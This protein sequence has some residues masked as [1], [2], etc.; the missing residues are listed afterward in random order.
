ML[1]IIGIGA[2]VERPDVQQMRV[3]GGGVSDAAAEIAAPF[4]QEKM[5]RLLCQPHEVNGQQGA[6]EAGPDDADAA[7]PSGD[8]WCGSHLISPL[9]PFVPVVPSLSVV[10][11]TRSRQWCLEPVGNGKHVIPIDEV[12]NLRNDLRTRLLKRSNS[13]A[14]RIR[15]QERN[16]GDETMDSVTETIRRTAIFFFGLGALSG[17]FMIAMRLVG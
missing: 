16:G 12:G 2:H 15:H 5:R 4:H 17:A 10:P 9:C 11:A 13:G 6:G 1:W 3:V 7:F 8:R 14:R